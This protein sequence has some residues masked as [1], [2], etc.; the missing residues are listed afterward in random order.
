MNPTVVLTLVLLLAATAACVAVV[1]LSREAVATARSLRALSDDVRERLV[2]LLDKADV[3]VDAANAELLRIDGAITRFEDA[4]AR[5]SAASNTLA[6]V[7]QAPADIVTG[8]ADR[9]RRA[10][11]ERRQHGADAESV[12]APGVEDDDAEADDVQAAEET[13]EPVEAAGEVDDTSAAASEGT[14]DTL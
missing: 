8:V 1:W 13:V 14:A 6:D 5:V 3:T 12:V 7:V 4:S 10:W 9:V 2:P 11:K